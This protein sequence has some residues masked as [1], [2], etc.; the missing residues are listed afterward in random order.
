[1]NDKFNNLSEKLK[2]KKNVHE[3]QSIVVFG[4]LNF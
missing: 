1:M 2:T 3:F 4:E